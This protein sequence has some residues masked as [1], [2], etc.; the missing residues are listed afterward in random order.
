VIPQ[1][2]GGTHFRVLPLPACYVQFHSATVS[3]YEEEGLPAWKR[4]KR[5]W[6]RCSLGRTRSQRCRCACFRT[7]RAVSAA[8]GR[9]D[10]TPTAQVR[11][12][13]PL[14]PLDRFPVSLPGW[15][16]QQ[17]SSPAPRSSVASR[18]ARGRAVAGRGRKDGQA[19][20]R[21]GDDRG[22]HR[23]GSVRQARTP[24]ERQ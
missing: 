21:M 19:D 7:P 22:T 6:T 9:F 10:R 17:R 8:I 14:Q 2:S 18:R 23:V 12:N 4:A 3:T 16:H 5:C 11:S 1:V 20:G 13:R 15:H 24:T